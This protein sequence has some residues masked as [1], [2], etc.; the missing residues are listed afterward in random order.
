MAAEP[1]RGIAL[2]IGVGRY[3]HPDVPRLDH[4]VADADALADLLADPDVC[5]F[6]ADQVKRLTDA[7]AGRDAVVE[8]LSGWLPARSGGAEIA[9][10]YFAGH[11][12]APAVGGRREGYLLPHDAD[13]RNPAV[14]GVAMADLTKWVAGVKAETVVVCLDCCHAG[15]AMTFRDADRDIG[16]RPED[17]RRMAGKGRFLMAACDE[18]QRSA[19]VAALGHGLFTGFLLRGIERDGDL[20]G[21]GKVGLDELFTYVSGAVAEAARRLGFE[22]RPWK[23]SA[24][25]GREYISRRREG[26]PP[27]AGAAAEPGELLADIRR[28]AAG[29]AGPTLESLLREAGKVGSP[30]AVPV[31]I[32]HLANDDPAVART[33]KEVMQAIG[34]EPTFA[35]VEE[36]ARRRSP[37]LGAVL[38]GLAVL[39]ARADLVALLDRVVDHAA[40]AE[41]VQAANLVAVKRLRLGM[42]DVRRLFAANQVPY[43]LIRPLGKGQ[44]T[45]AY[46]ADDPDGGM[47]VVV[48]VLLGSYARADDAGVRRQFFGVCQRSLQ[49]RSE[50]VV[51]THL[52][53]AFRTD[54]TYYT[55]REYLDSPTL[56]QVLAGRPPDVPGRQFSPAQSAE[57]VRQLLTGLAAVHAAGG[58][59]GAV[60]PS[61][62]FLCPGDWVVLGDLAPVLPVGP[63]GADARGAY[64]LRYTPPEVFRGDPAEPRTD[65]YAL[66]CV[67]YELFCGAPPFP[68]DR[69]HDQYIGHTG[70]AVPPV[71]THRPDLPG[72]VQAFLR[73]LLA[74]DPAARP[75]AAEALA[76]LEAV[77][78]ALAGPAPRPQA[79]ADAA[80]YYHAGSTSVG[81]VSFA[82]LRAATAGRLSPSD[83]VWRVGTPDWVVAASVPG[84]FESL[85]PPERTAVGFPLVPLVRDKSL[86][87]YRPAQTRMTVG[88]DRPLPP[89]TL[90]PDLR[91]PD[92][93]STGPRTGS[94]GRP[95]PDPPGDV[96]PTLIGGYEIVRVLGRGGMGVVYEAFDPR[97]SRR[98]AI[99]TMHPEFGRSPVGRARF[100]RE[101]RAAAALNH[102]NVVPIYQVD[103]DAGQLFLVM[104]LLSGQTLQDHLRRVK[105]LSTPDLLRVAIDVARGLAAAH[106]RG[107]IHRDIKPANIWLDQH[108]GRALILDFGLARMANDVG[109][110]LTAAGA[111]AGTPGYMSP[112][113]VQG[114]RSVDAR[115]DLWSLGLTLY[116]MATGRLAFARENGLASLYAVVSEEPTPVRDAAPFLPP[117]LA[118]LIWQ[119]MR[120]NPADRPS[121]AAEVAVRLRAIAA[122]LVADPDPGL[123]PVVWDSLPPLAAE[124]LSETSVEPPPAEELSSEASVENPR[125]ARWRRLWR[126]LRGRGPS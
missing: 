92:D 8:H 121:S 24:T 11:G 91:L 108:D 32:P 113:Q 119:L 62:V 44:L 33:A 52:V 106:D 13:P 39:A 98:V 14:R 7:D 99:K 9:V 63:A 97:L 10:I 107:L 45:A 77:R 58:G 1:R 38:G 37:D 102:P 67:A 46:L 15:L 118:E 30:L 120:K 56:Q 26:G 109:D 55:V 81:P 20:D 16:I 18:G 72:E 53:R 123:E 117:A 27:A 51:K 78:A 94:A 60:R 96:A 100:A 4:A 110:N 116:Q 31:V 73:R 5:G 12:V 90:P 48:R 86:A 76:E 64:N 42:E 19:E 35:A 17:V 34:I 54:G 40:G 49:L 3:A 124:S 74:L 22:Q 71:R 95:E 83:L 87:D 88:G 28:R 103:E 125:P 66:G 85:A 6:P 21:D 47:R 126:W 122:D 82:E 114:Y 104:P 115:T 111:I 61:N 89:Q 84:L 93:D 101:A 29:A 43:E 2:V 112:E 36:L 69:F 57:I 25:T 80:W 70:G 59:H 65:L 50:Y 41:L 105:T 23:E 79:S 75:T 68:S